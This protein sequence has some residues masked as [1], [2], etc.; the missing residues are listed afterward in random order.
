MSQS[1]LRQIRDKIGN[2]P[3]FI[4]SEGQSKNSGRW[5][6]W[7][8]DLPPFMQIIKTQAIELVIKSVDTAEQ[9][10][11]RIS[12]DGMVEVT[13][14]TP[15]IPTALGIT[16]IGTFSD[17]AKINNPQMG[18]LLFTED[19]QTTYIWDG[20]WV[21]LRLEEQVTSTTLTQEVIPGYDTREELEKKHQQA[22]LEEKK[23]AYYSLMVLD[24]MSEAELVSKVRDVVNYLM[25][26]KAS[27][28][29]F[30]AQGKYKQANP[31]TWFHL[32]D[33]MR[34]LSEQF[35]EYIL[36]LEVVPGPDSDGILPGVY[37]FFQG[38]MQHCP[39]R[40]VNQIFHAFEVE[41]YNPEKLI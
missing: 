21:A 15:T 13:S 12:R 32:E 16:H 34:S 33:N 4:D 27:P 9:Q 41:D 24:P 28:N 20:V 25:Q 40:F 26:N 1:I 38:R 23:T 36:R 5:L 35:A 8:Q 30:N 7:Y 17:A 22:L 11:W 18:D 10:K 2:A 14:T 3:Y 39:A 29:F 6:N 31:S 19:T 37:Y